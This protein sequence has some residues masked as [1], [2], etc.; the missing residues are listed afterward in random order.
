MVYSVLTNQ[1]DIISV[2]KELL[3]RAEVSFDTETSSLETHSED[4]KIAG[5]GFTWESNQGVYIPFNYD[6]GLSPDDLLDLF[7]PVLESEDIG[8]I[9][10]N[11]KYDARVCNRFGINLQNITF[12]THLASYCLYSDRTTHNLDDLSLHFLNRVKIRTKNLLKLSKSENLYN[13]D[14]IIVGN[15]CAED[16]DT[17]W[18]LTEYFR[19]LFSLEENKNARDLFYNIELP[20]LPV[21]I[22]M[23]CA[24]VKLDIDYLDKLRERLK[25]RQ[26]RLTKFLT[27]KVGREIAL[28]NPNDIETALYDELKVQKTKK[29]PT[30]PKSGKRK[31]DRDTLELFSDN[32]AVRSILLIKKYQKLLNTYIIP[33]PKLISKYTGLLHASFNQAATSTGRFASSGPNLQNIPARDPIGKAIRASF[34]SRW[35][36]IGGKILAVDLSQAELRILA[37]LSKDPT[38]VSAYINKEDVHQ[39]VCDLL[40]AENLPVEITRS[41]AKT[42]NF[43]M[44]YGV[45]PKKMGLTLGCDMGVASKFIKTYLKQMPGVANYLETTKNFLYK[46]GYTETLLGRRRYIPKIYSGETMDKWAAEREAC[47]FPVQGTN[48]DMIKIAMADIY[49]HIQDQNLKSCIILQVH[50]ELVLD[51]HPDEIDIMKPLVI[52]SMESAIQLDVPVVAEGEYHDNWAGAH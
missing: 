39:K 47:N 27:S 38:L 48:A 10:Q 2:S 4:I 14:P 46:H 42:A 9:G 19:Y 17:V 41:I 33:I 6:H 35:K 20:T 23:E 37:H 21:V 24:G 8:K 7:K 25:R 51:V 18:R 52:N 13:L 22:S 31:T 43:A 45:G 34:I 40:A 30:T 44:I 49:Q 26:Q 3:N 1:K 5:F 32:T 12:D 16:T 15:Y 50:D 28:T 36:D 29:I 11:L